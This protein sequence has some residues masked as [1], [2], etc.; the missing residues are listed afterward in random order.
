MASKGELIFC[1]GTLK[2]GQPNN[3]I[4]ID[5]TTGHA[6]FICQGCAK[7]KYPLIIASEYNIPYLLYAE[8]KGYVRKWSFILSTLLSALLVIVLNTALLLLTF[9]CK[10]RYVVIC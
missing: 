4:I 6:K 10:C 1:Y 7:H 3:K 2:K 5:E 8:G 9:Q